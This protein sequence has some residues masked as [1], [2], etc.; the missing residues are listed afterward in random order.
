[1]VAGGFFLSNKELHTHH[2]YKM[3]TLRPKGSANS[4]Y[5]HMPGNGPL[6][7]GCMAAARFAHQAIFFGGYNPRNGANG[8]P[9]FYNEVHYFD[10][11][12]QHWA[13]NETTGDK[14]C[15]RAQAKA[16]AF[17]GRFYLFGGRDDNVVYNDLYSMDIN[18]RV[19]KKHATSGPAPPA[20]KPALTMDQILRGEV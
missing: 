4:F 13:L 19:W 2:T 9:R 6:H 15:P 12:Q 1:M 8:R 3:M 11:R 16:I 10:T 18:T 7:R 14:P 20:G 5:F 17:D